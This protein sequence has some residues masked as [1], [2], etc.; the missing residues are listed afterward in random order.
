MQLD[1]AMTQDYK[2]CLFPLYKSPSNLFGGSYYSEAAMP[3]VIRIVHGCILS[4]QLGFCDPRMDLLATSL[5][6]GR[7]HN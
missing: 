2:S 1:K 3:G 5:H 7:W 4:G 6:K